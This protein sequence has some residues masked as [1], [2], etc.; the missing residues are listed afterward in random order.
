MLTSEPSECKRLGVVWQSAPFPLW[1]DWKKGLEWKAS[2]LGADTL[3]LRR[4]YF[5]FAM[6]TAYR[7][8]GRLPR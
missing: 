3:V 5:G 2:K 7:C 4:R 6:A 8:V 1:N